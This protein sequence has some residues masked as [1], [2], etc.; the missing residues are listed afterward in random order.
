[1]I[2]I[3]AAYFAFW[4][5]LKLKGENKSGPP[6]QKPKQKENKLL[7]SLYCINNFI[8]AKS[9]SENNFCWGLYCMKLVVDCHIA[10]V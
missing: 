1:M 2:K 9:I 4:T 3:V 10:I 5:E 8:N 7:Y 6:P